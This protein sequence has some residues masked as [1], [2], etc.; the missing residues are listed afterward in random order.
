MILTQKALVIAFVASLL[1]GA[2]SF[3]SRG[4]Y[5]VQEFFKELTGSAIGF[6]LI[7]IG[8][9]LYPVI[10]ADAWVF[11]AICFVT[12]RL[13]APILSV[14]LWRLERVEVTANIGVVNLKST[15]KEDD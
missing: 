10:L 5:T 15:G 9:W 1:G 7:L 11:G 6:S 4:R 13:T 14:F 3:V 12:A 2:A 8:A